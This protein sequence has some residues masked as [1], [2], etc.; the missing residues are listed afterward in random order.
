MQNPDPTKPCGQVIVDQMDKILE[1]LQCD[2]PHLSLC[3]LPTE[4]LREDIKYD[5]DEILKQLRAFNFVETIIIRQQGFAR[6][7][8]FSDFLNR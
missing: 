4:S 8:T 1:I 7:V 6:R 3:I 2:Y 5:A